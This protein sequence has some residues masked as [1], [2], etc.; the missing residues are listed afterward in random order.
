M[1]AFDKLGKLVK[2]PFGLN[3]WRFEIESDVG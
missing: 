3:P 1:A 2:L